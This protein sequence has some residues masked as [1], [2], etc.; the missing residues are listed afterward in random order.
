MSED[1]YFDKLPQI[2]Y[3]NTDSIDITRRI[4]ITDVAYYDPYIFYTYDISEHERP[5]QFSYRYFDDQYKSWILYLSNKIV[6]PYYEW[7]MTNDE[8]NSFLNTKYGSVVES[9]QKIDYYRNDWTNSDSLET[10]GYEALAFSLKKYWHPVYDSFGNILEYKRI[11][12]DWKITTNKIVSYEVSNTN[13]I[14]NEICNIVFTAANNGSGQVISTSNTRVY[15]KHLSGTHLESNTITIS[16]SSYIYGNDSGIN[17]IFTSATL[18][19][20]NIAPE[21]EVY[22]KGITHF[23]DELEKNEFNKT[24]RV[25]DSSLAGNVVLNLIDLFEE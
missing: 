3:S 14:E 19:S 23:D 17:T 1:R 8:F 24:I 22:W 9:Q 18:V 5:D 4:S 7:Y 25:I 2:K 15:L 13:F 21:E 20:N 6:D 12:K 10:N 16:G 11:P